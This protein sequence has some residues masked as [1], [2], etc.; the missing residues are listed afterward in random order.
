LIKQAYSDNAVSCTWVYECYSRFWDGFE[1]LKDDKYGGQPTAVQ[2]PD[3]IKTV[4][5]L[6]S[7]DC[8][9]TVRMMEEILEISRETIH[10]TL[11]EGLRKQKIC[12]RF[13]PHCSTDEQKAL[14]LQACQG[15]IQSLDDD[16]PLLDSL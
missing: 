14:R 2:T 3:M 6:I 4:Q 16:R 5:E 7:T 13:I 8:H 12:T 15:F 10:K 9:M 11:V 1:N